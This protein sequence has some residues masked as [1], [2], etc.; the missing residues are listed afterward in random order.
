VGQ[1]R[2]IT[3]VTQSVYHAKQELKGMTE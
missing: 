2:Q 1:L 3:S